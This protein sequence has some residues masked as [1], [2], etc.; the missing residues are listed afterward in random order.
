MKRRPIDLITE[1][2]QLSA[3]QCFWAAADLHLARKDSLGAMQSY[4][5]GRSTGYRTQAHRTLLSIRSSISKKAWHNPKNPNDPE[6]IIG[7][8]KAHTA[9]LRRSVDIARCLIDSAA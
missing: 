5:R 9:G 3:S 7:I 8:C 6:T 4:Y 2:A 1:L